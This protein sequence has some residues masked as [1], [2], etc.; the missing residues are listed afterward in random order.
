MR[1]RKRDDGTRAT[2]KETSKQETPR[3]A[4]RKN[5]ERSDKKPI[6]GHREDDEGAGGNGN[7]AGGG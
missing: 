1:R 3:P 2:T 6:R 4:R 7:V 5:G